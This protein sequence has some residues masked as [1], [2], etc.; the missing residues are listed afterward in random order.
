[1]TYLVEGLE[2]PLKILLPQ[3]PVVTLEEGWNGGGTER[4]EA[5]SAGVA[6][7][8][9]Y[10]LLRCTDGKSG[11]A[12]RLSDEEGG[13]KGPAPPN[14]GVP[15]KG[16]PK[17]LPPA[18]KGWVNSEAQSLLLRPGVER[19]LSKGDSTGEVENLLG[20]A[21][22]DRLTSLNDVEDSL[23]RLLVRGR[24]WRRWCHFIQ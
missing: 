2:T 24:I 21:A 16:A 15:R 7:E 17:L 22:Q 6:G 8:I 23:N 20:F 18:M 12:T 13:L 11:G 9:A 3:V 19:K 5:S 10:M 4:G 14:R 1:M